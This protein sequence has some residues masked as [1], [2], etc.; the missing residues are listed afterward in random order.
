[1]DVKDYRVENGDWLFPE[2]TKNFDRLLLQYK[3]DLLYLLVELFL[4]H[5]FG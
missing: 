5:T 3:V 1:M 4:L 2:S